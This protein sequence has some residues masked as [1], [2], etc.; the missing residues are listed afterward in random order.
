MATM[1]VEEA[2]SER[3]LPREIEIVWETPLNPPKPEDYIFYD[4]K[5]MVRPY[6]FEFI[7]H[8]KKRW[9]GK[10][11][12]DV[13]SH[14][15]R[16]RPH[17]Y[18][19]EAVKSGRIRVDGKLVAIGYVVRDGEKLSHFVHRHEPPVMAEPVVIL[20]EGC[21]VVTVCKPASVPIEAGKVQ[22]E[23]VAK[24]KGIFPTEEVEVD[25]NV[26]YDAREG[27]STTQVGNGDKEQ[28]ING[29]TACTRFTRLATDGVFS[30]V[31]CL[32][33]TGRTHQIRVHLQ[34]LGH[35]IAND[36]L[37]SHANPP[38]RTRKETSADLAAK[39]SQIPTT[40]MDESKLALRFVSEQCNS[41]EGASLLSN[42]DVD[43]ESSQ[44][45]SQLR[46]NVIAILEGTNKKQKL[47]GN[48]IVGMRP[49]QCPARGSCNNFQEGSIN[50]NQR[51]NKDHSEKLEL[52][53]SMDP[54][55]TNCPNVAPS[56]YDDHEEALW[57]HC[58]RYS[59]PHWVY[60]CPLPKWAFI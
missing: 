16:Q 29:K 25:A 23:Y 33:L 37:Y 11:V 59:G 55:C 51:L 12:V 42:K 21:D 13:F 34:H 52:D 50:T 43:L 44:R 24:V 18:Y 49:Y 60:E 57:L 53:F 4:G 58:F 46:S 19:V 54:M 28:P 48:S 6:Y 31:K 2:K 30:V 56:G 27:R 38:S 22:K 1:A 35:S 7:A 15:F 8:V 39:V 5:R 45:G 36:A 47:E 17:E 32:P 3:E 26:A 9:A 41:H 20:E 14:E 10:K 40:D